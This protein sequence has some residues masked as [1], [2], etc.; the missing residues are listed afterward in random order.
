MKT[1]QSIIFIINKRSTFRFL[2][3]QHCLFLSVSHAFKLQNYT[4]KLEFSWLNNMEEDKDC[5]SEEVKTLTN[6]NSEGQNVFWYFIVLLLIQNSKEIVKI[7]NIVAPIFNLPFYEVVPDLEWM[8]T[9][10]K[11][12][13]CKPQNP[14]GSDDNWGQYN[15]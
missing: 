1:F 12:I 9:S 14:W 11:W 13:H 10:G 6:E 15:N 3:A 8:S 4:I 2:N 7:C 5:R